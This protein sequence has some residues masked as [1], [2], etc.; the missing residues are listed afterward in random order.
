MTKEILYYSQIVQNS[1]EREPMEQ[2]S[3]KT[4]ILNFESK[5]WHLNVFLCFGD[6]VDLFN[7]C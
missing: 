5:S 1:W 6:F 3:S 2:K 4:N 7:H